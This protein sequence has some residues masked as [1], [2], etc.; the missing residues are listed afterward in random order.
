MSR[1]D[2]LRKE[3]VDYPL[4]YSWDSLAAQTVKKSA[5]NAGDLG[6]E[7]PLEKGKSTHSS[8]LAWRIPWT[9]VHGVTKSQTQLSDFHFPLSVRSIPFLSFIEPIF[10]WNVPWVSLIF[11]KRSLVFLILFFP[12]FLC[13]DH[14]GRL[15]YL[16]LL[17]FGT[18]HS[19]GYIFPF[20]LGLLL[21][22][23]SQLFVRPPK[24]TILPFCISFS[25]GWFWP[26]T[27]YNVTNLRP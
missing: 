18:L 21:L 12:L 15:S 22:F 1:E 5:C 20:L 24:T 13:I 14:W 23:F 10:A 25:W 4:Q 27:P 8:I 9:I 7:D 2:T 16:S 19:G 3:G 17:F 26:L 11:L 6:W